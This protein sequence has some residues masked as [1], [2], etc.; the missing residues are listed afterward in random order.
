[1]IQRHGVIQAVE[2]VVTKREVS[3]GFTALE[4]MGLMDYAFEAV[5]LRH[6]QHFSAEAIAISKQ[7]MEQL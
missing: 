4:A 1:M 7:R 3:S 6:P 2:R 5:I